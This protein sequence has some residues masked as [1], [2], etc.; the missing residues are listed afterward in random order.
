L[1]EYLAERF[2]LIG[3]P[4]QCIA[5]VRQMVEAGATNLLLTALVADKARL[6][7]TLS[8]RVLPSFR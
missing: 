1:K 2:A 3:T 4:D 7:R 8:A 5:R 6:I